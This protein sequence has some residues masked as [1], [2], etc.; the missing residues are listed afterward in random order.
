MYYAYIIESASSGKWYYGSTENLEVR[1]E[2]HNKGLNVSTR[3]RG[4]WKY[5][6]VRPFD[7]KSD[8]RAFELRLKKLR[9]KEFIRREFALFFP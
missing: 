8:A 6:F 7:A 1:L 2:G 3:N 9:N 5:I 4:P